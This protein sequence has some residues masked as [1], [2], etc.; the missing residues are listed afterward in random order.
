MKFICFLCIQKRLHVLRFLNLTLKDFP[1]MCPAKYVA[2]AKSHE[3]TL[4]LH[5][6]SINMSLK[7][8]YRKFHLKDKRFFARIESLF[9]FLALTY[10]ALH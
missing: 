1:Q 10:S 5:I 8:A 9:L 6:E 4:I 7:H 2:H 3:K